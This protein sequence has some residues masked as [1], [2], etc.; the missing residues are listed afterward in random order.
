MRKTS[1]PMTFDD[2]PM[3]TGVRYDGTRTQ[4]T[5]FWSRAHI[6]VNGD[7]FH[8]ID[9]DPEFQRDHVWSVKQQRAFVEYARRGGQESL[10]VIFNL[11]ARQP[12]GFKGNWIPRYTCIDGKQRLTAIHAFM[13]NKL[14]VFGGVT[15]DD[16]VRNSGHPFPWSDYRITVTTVQMPYDDMLRFYLELNSNGTPHSDAEITK[17]RCMLAKITK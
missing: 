17:V 4:E 16:L 1:K 12:K 13:T 7:D 6:F 2:I 3:L 8:D 10:G 14:K 15:L 9:L 5:V 11:Q